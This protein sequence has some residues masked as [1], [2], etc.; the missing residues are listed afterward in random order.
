MRK[1]GTPV[2]PSPSRSACYDFTTLNR[3]STLSSPTDDGATIARIARS[4]LADLDTTG[5]VPAP[6]CRRLRPRRLGAGGPLRRDGRGRGGRGGGRAEPRA[7]GRG[8]RA[9]RDGRLLA[10]TPPPTPPGPVRSFRADDPALHRWEPRPR[11]DDGRPHPA[12]A[13]PRRRVAAG[14]RVEVVVLD[15]GDDRVA[16]RRRVVGQEHHGLPRRRQL[17]GT[18]HDPSLAS[19]PPRRSSARPVSRRP[20]RSLS[21]ATAYD[22]PSSSDQPSGRAS[23]RAARDAAAAHRLA[24]SYDDR[25]GGSGSGPVGP[26][27]ST[28]PAASR[29]GPTHA[30]VSVERDPSTGATAIPPA[31]AT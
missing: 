29:G 19:S 18:E 13:A 20:I 9:R 11:S 10:R 3:S 22:A 8:R 12:A 4:L 1:N 2:G 6:R 25:R 17:D 14:R 26:S 30:S 7:A 24:G 23:R 28:S 15:H 21:G 5:G 31:K 16:A 27:T